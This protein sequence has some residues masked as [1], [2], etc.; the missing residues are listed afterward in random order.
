MMAWQPPT[1]IS[2]TDWAKWQKDWGN[3]A[4][5]LRWRGLLHKEAVVSPVIG[6]TKISHLESAVQSLCSQAIC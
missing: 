4:V 1:N 6:A 5:R 2:S 3:R